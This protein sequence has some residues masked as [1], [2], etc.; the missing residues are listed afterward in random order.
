M[1]APLAGRA[2]N[3]DVRDGAKVIKKVGSSGS[4][5]EEG[6]RFACMHCVAEG[7]E[8]VLDVPRRKVAGYREGG[9]DPFQLP[10]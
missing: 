3:R 9:S 2:V 10:D 5:G 4:E 7:A 1:G 8:E 6:D